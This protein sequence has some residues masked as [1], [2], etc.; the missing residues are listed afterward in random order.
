MRLESCYRLVS[1][2]RVGTSSVDQDTLYIQIEYVL[3][4][5]DNVLAESDT[6]AHVLPIADP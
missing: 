3:I 6:L 2:V 4:D 5:G 1:K